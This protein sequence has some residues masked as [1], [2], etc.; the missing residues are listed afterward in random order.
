[1]ENQEIRIKRKL[2]EQ[3]E[4]NRIRNRFK[5]EEDTK[6][7]EAPTNIF[8]GINEDDF[9]IKSRK[10]ISSNLIIAGVEDIDELEDDEELIQE[11]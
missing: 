10:I 7:K 4:L 11:R 5:K 9:T 6:E 1:M 3:E 2:K 8:D